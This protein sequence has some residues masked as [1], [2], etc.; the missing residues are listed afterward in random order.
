[1]NEIHSSASLL[2]MLLSISKRAISSKEGFQKYLKRQKE[3]SGL[4]NQFHCYVGFEVHCQLNVPNKLFSL[5]STQ[6][7]AEKEANTNLGL[8]DIAYPGI[9]PKINME[10]VKKAILSGIALK[11]QISNSLI[12]D[13]K[14]Y[15]YPDLPNAYQI[16]QKFHPIAEN[17]IFEY[18]DKDFKISKLGI[19]RIQLEQDSARVMN[20]VDFTCLDFRRANIP[21]IEIVTKPEVR[22]PTDGGLAMGQ[23]QTIL[24]CNEISNAIIEEVA[25]LLGS[26]EMRY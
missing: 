16:T 17:G 14:H 5:G 8:F 9:L 24:K 2:Y 26:N 6:V 1:M 7:T 4:L 13:R 19:E 23:L 3:I 18:F 10:C 12:F 25:S 22:Y 15:F 21:L 20:E 11:C